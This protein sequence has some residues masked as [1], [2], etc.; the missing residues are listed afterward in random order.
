MG[1]SVAEIADMYTRQWLSD[2]ERTGC[3]PPEVICRAT[4]HIPEQI[5]M[6]GTLEEKGYTYRIDDEGLIEHAQ[7]IPPTSQNQAT[8]EDD[9]R[10]FVQPRVD[11]ED[12]ELRWQ[13]EQAVRNYDPCIS[14]STH[15]LE[16]TVHR[17]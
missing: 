7:I 11:M 12:D 6:V 4:E 13:C 8:I 15:F 9:L 2:R 16:L 17:R 5:D 14:C 3:L 10:D 1:K